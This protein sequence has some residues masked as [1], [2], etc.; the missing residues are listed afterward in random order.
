MRRQRRRL[1]ILAA[2]VF[3]VGAVFALASATDEPLRRELERRMN[4]SLEGYTVVLG[5]ASFQPLGLAVDVH[6]LV[7]HQEAHPEPPVAHF[8]RMRASVQWSALLRGAVVADVQFER[9]AL[10][11]DR[12]HVRSEVRDDRAIQ[13]RGWQDA[14][15]A[16]YPLRINEVSI[17]GGSLTY[18]DEG[19]FEP[20][21]ITQLEARAE[22]IRNIKVAEQ[23][24]PSTLSLTG[25]VFERGRVRLSGNANFM[26]KPHPAV[27]AAVA[28]DELVLDYLGPLAERYNL[29]LSGG[30]L[31]AVGVVEHRPEHTELILQKAEISGVRAEYVHTGPTAPREKARARRTAEVARETLRKPEFALQIDELRVAASRLGFVNRASEPE[32]RVFLED[33]ELSVSNLSNRPE[34]GPARVRLDGR[35]MGSG[36]ARV[37]AVVR[38]EQ[39]GTDLGFDVQLRDT[40]MRKLNPLLRAYGSLD[41]VRGSF[42]LYSEISIRDGRVDGYVKPLFR[43]LD[44]Y[45]VQQDSGENPI[46]QLYEGLAGGVAGLLENSEREEVAT[47]TDLSGPLEDPDTSALQVVARLV[48]NAFF[49]A[50]LPGLDREARRGTS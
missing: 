32:Y 8:G 46:T 27:R 18:L 50:I 1:R 40:D 37:T 9:P 23:D 19:P 16:V 33:G 12:T 41:V 11:V 49:K 17:R 38:P 48:Q 47:K 26:L 3:L 34:A 22:N 4:A 42:S 13:E 10:H 31:S 45:S 15:Q 44:V 14:L 20:L 43:N 29:A 24:Y 30:T 21:R 2:L 35:F 7:I 5:R 28:I 6:D 36:D 39:D 25:V